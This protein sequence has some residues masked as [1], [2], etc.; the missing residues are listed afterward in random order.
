MRLVSVLPPASKRQ[1]S[2]LVALAEKSAKL[3]PFPSQWAPRGYGE[4]S[5]TVLSLRSGA[6]MPYRDSEKQPSCRRASNWSTQSAE[7]FMGAARVPMRRNFATRPAAKRLVRRPADRGRRAI[8]S[9][10][11]ERSMTD[12]KGKNQGEGDKEADRNYRKRTTEFLKSEKG[13]QAVEH[14]GDVSEEEARKLKKYE[15]QGKARAKG[16]DPQIRHQ[17]KR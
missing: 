6:F 12:P 14:A 5:V 3:T 15:E 17:S 11:K 8:H 16:E 9:S 2:T 1:T 7:P 13:Q 10:T 4:P